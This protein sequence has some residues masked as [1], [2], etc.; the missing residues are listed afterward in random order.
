MKLLFVILQ[1]MPV[2]TEF[3]LKLEELQKKADDLRRA[4][5]EFERVLAESGNDVD[6]LRREVMS[7]VD[8]KKM[9]DLL[10]MIIDIK[11]R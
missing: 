10:N 8:Q 9:H 2:K 7:V 5:L 4:V 11:D 3:N 1:Y 6:H